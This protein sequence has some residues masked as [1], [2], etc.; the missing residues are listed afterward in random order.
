M[1]AVH[2]GLHEIHAAGVGDVAGRSGLISISFHAAG[3]VIGVSFHAI[4]N[5]GTAYISVGSGVVV[6]NISL[7]IS[8]SE[9]TPSGY[10]PGTAGSYSS[11]SRRRS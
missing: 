4:G 8:G 6:I 5:G 3:Q 7:T 10:F 1:D 2:V 9:R 11:R